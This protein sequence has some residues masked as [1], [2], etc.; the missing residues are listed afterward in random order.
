[1]G[2]KKLARLVN[3]TLS[4]SCSLSLQGIFSTRKK[5]AMRMIK[6]LPVAF[7]AAILCAAISLPGFAQSIKPGV[8]DGHHAQIEH[9]AYL[10]KDVAGC[11]DC[12]TP[13]SAKGQPVPGQ[14]L[15]GTRLSFAPL[16]P[17]PGWAD[18]SPRIAGLDGWTT[19]Q[20]IRLLMTGTL[21]NG[22]R[23]R[24]PMPQFRMNHA[25]AAAVVAYLKSLK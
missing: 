13:M 15:Q 1:M 16:V 12:H 8:N 20:A 18:A 24:P 7:A 10:V 22:Q 6:S 11:S 25:D 2:M 4:F 9:G 23:L 19:E 5:K 3:R 17:F 21:P 14:W